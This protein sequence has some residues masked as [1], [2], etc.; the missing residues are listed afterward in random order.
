[1]KG[2][3]SPK[4]RPIYLKRPAPTPIAAVGFGR[5]KLLVCLLDD[6]PDEAVRSVPST[7]RT[8]AR[9][10]VI[11]DSGIV[12]WQSELVDAPAHLLREHKG[13]I[14]AGLWQEQ[15]KLLPIEASRHV[16]GPNH[17][18]SDRLSDLS[19]AIVASDARYHHGAIRDKLQTA[20]PQPTSGSDDDVSNIQSE[21]GCRRLPAL[22]RV[23]ANMAGRNL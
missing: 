6:V 15:D 2:C 9:R 13:A 23:D 3:G 18:R 14:E 17:P 5:V 4:G 20:F 19:Q 7:D 21:P 16:R 8:E 1:M 10:D 22:C 11:R 12:V